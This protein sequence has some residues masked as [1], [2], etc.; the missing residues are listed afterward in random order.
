MTATASKNGYTRLPTADPDQVEGA[1][2]TGGYGG[3]QFGPHR[4][5]DTAGPQIRNGKSKKKGSLNQRPGLFHMF[6]DRWK[7]AANHV[8]AALASQSES[9]HE[10]ERIE[11]T[12]IKPKRPKLRRG[13]L[14]SNSRSPKM[15]KSRQKFRFHII[16]EPI[17]PGDTVQ[18][19]AL[20]YGCPVSAYVHIHCCYCMLI[21]DPDIALLF[22]FSI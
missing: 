2:A 9:E 13:R 5:W 6:G 16:E 3:I 17:L 4:D 7:Y 12:E 14:K 22:S 11:L 15:L 20:R 8:S 18:R 10:A 21:I 19:V 1:G